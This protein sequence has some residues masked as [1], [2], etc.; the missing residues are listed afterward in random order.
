MESY[1]KLSTTNSMM[2]FGF[3]KVSVFCK[4]TKVIFMPAFGNTLYRLSVHKAG[5]IEL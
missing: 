1:L 5:Y 4:A 3:P 2:F